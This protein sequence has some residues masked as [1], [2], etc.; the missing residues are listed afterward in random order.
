MNTQTQ[1]L[2]CLLIIF[3]LSIPQITFSQN[4]PVQGATA[5][6]QYNSVWNKPLQTE[7]ERTFDALHYRIELDFDMETKSFEG[8][9]TIS[10][11]PLLGGFDRVLLDAKEIVIVKVTILDNEELE[12]K[13]DST[14]VEIQLNRIYRSQEL[15]KLTVFY[16]GSGLSD[17]L[18]FHDASDHNPE[19]VE[20]NSWPNHARYWFPCYDYPNDKVTHEVIV[21]VDKPFK[22]ISN[23]ELINVSEKGERLTYHWYQKKPH[24]TYLSMLSIAPFSILK[25]SLG[26]LPINYWV[27]QG[28]ESNALRVLSITPEVIEFFN[29]IYNYNYPWSKYDQV[30]GPM[31][32]GGAEATSATIL[33]MGAIHDPDPSKDKSWRR[34]VAH[35]IAH[36]WWGNLITLRTWSETWMNESFGTYSDYLYT[37]HFLGEPDASIDLDAKKKAYLKE[38]KNKYQRPIVHTRYSVPQDNFDRHTYQKGASVLNMLRSIIGH[39]AFYKTLSYF[40]HK[41]EFQVVDTHDFVVAVKEATGMN[42]DWFFDQ[43]IYKPGHPVFK[44][45]RDWNNDNSELKMEIKQ[46]QDTINGTPV[47][48]IPVTIGIYSEG[49]E[50]IF[51]EVCLEDRTES[52]TWSLD[53]KPNMVRFDV[54]NTL[55]KEWSYYKELDEL[56]YQIANDDVIGKIWAIEQLDAI[57]EFGL[58]REVTELLEKISIKDPLW[59]VRVAS[60]DCLYRLN[61]QVDLNVLAKAIHDSHF[62]VRNKAKAISQR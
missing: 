60:L 28:D 56:L 51:K 4:N 41:H 53:K 7:R 45:S 55:L 61:G 43:W 26:D 29:S 62:S 30:I 24:S 19:M 37:E 46:L 34:I 42:M 3:I 52:F 27:Y 8:S 20:S 57:F 2:K 48:R 31:Q 13:Q 23:G 9:N 36:Q 14:S 50:P 39:E 11:K 25:D 38:A 17:G 32:G 15:I 58:S 18:F 59:P 21:T 16:K 22:V 40:L 6:K 33:G 44:I 12:F 35:E 49:R 54:G 47:F 10:L 1:F 5:S